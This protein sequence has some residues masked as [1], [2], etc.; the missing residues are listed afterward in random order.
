MNVSIRLWMKRKRCL[1]QQYEK[2][3]EFAEQQGPMMQELLEKNLRFHTKQLDYL[4]GK[5][6]EAVLLKHDAVLRTFGILEGELFPDGVLQ[7]RLYTPYTYLNSYGPTL[8]QDLLELPFEMD[9][10]HKIIY[11]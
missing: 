4:K 6:E 10:T 2:I 3:A 8:I 1:G 11:L 9:G 7:E 5:A